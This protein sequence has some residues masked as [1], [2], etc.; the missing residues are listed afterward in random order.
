VPVRLGDGIA[1]FPRFLRVL[2]RLRFEGWLVIETQPLIDDATAWAAENLRRLRGFLDRARLP[3][4]RAGT[5][6]GGT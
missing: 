1:D 6:R 5:Q 2:L 3:E 4:A